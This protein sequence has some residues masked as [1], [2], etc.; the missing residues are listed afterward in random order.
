MKLLHDIKLQKSISNC[1]SA[2]INDASSCY[3]DWTDISFVFWSNSY[4]LKRQAVMN[5]HL[6]SFFQGEFHLEY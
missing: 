4:D 3:C 1:I 6:H 5:S 2:Y